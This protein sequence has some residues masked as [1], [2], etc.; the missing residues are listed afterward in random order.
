M[1]FLDLK[2]EIGKI[3]LLSDNPSRY[4]GPVRSPMDEGLRTLSF[5]KQSLFKPKSVIRPFWVV[6]YNCLPF[7]VIFYKKF[8]LTTDNSV[9]L[10]SET[11]GNHFLLNITCSECCF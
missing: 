1:L 7:C 11:G 4:R 9:K 2:Q 6:F 8:P 3:L 5:Q 10:L